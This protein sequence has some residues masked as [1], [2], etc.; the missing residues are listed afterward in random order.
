M[1]IHGWSD[2]MAYCTGRDS[3]HQ[4]PR[5][6]PP[7]APAAVSPV[8]LARSRQVEAPVLRQVLRSR[9]ERVVRAD[10]SGHEPQG[11]R[12]AV[13]VRGGAVTTVRRWIETVWG[14]VS[15]VARM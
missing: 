13:Q 15:L 14:V 11:I 5:E 10:R 12:A 3:R 6:E 2:Q 9:W 1:K 4:S 8:R 7:P